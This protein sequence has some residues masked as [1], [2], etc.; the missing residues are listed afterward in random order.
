MG[1]NTKE[2]TNMPNQKDQIAKRRT[3]GKNVGDI[4]LV[5][6][7]QS[8]EE[9]E[10]MINEFIEACL[11]ESTSTVVDYDSMVSKG[12]VTVGE[13]TMLT[14]TNCG[15]NTTR[16]DHM[17]QHL[18]LHNKDFCYHCKFC[19]TTCTTQSHYKVHLRKHTGVPTHHCTDC[20]F[21]TFTST[22]LQSHINQVH[23]NDIR[24][25][26]PACKQLF[27]S[28]KEMIE[29]TKLC[30]SVLGGQTLGHIGCR[31]S[32]QCKFECQ[33]QEEMLSHVKAKHSCDGICCPFCPVVVKNN[34]EMA[35]HR[36]VHRSY[37]CTKCDFTTEFK[38][39]YIKH[40]LQKHGKS[41]DFNCYFCGVESFSKSELD[42]H[43]SEHLHVSPDF[44]EKI[45]YK[46]LKCNYSTLKSKI[47][48]KK[49]CRRLHS[50]LGK[51]SCSE[52]SYKC[53]EVA[54][55]TLHMRKH[56]DSQHFLCQHCGFTCKWP[57]QMRLHKIKHEGKK[58][59]KCS[60]CSYEAYRSDSITVHKMHKH[61]QP[62]STMCEK[63]GGS[64]ST[65]A[66]FKKHMAMHADQEK[67]ANKKSTEINNKINSEISTTILENQVASTVSPSI[68]SCDSQDS[69]L[70]P[71]SNQ[72][73][74]VELSTNLANQSTMPDSNSLNSVYEADKRQL[75][76]PSVSPKQ[77]RTLYDQKK[78]PLKTAKNKK[79]QKYVSCFICQH[80]VKSNSALYQH[81]CKQHKQQEYTCEECS[82][83]T[84]TVSKFIVHKLD[85]EK[86]TAIKCPNKNCD[87]K[88]CTRHH[89]LLH[90]RKHQQKK[91]FACRSCLYTTKWPNQLK[92]HHQQKHAG[93]RNHKCPLCDYACY[94][95]DVLKSHI[96]YRHTNAR[97]HKCPTCSY[98]AKQKRSL[99]KHM[100][101]HKN[102]RPHT[103]ATCGKSFK[104]RQVLKH[105]ERG[106][107]RAFENHCSFCK[108]RCND[109]ALF[110]DHV[111][112]HVREYESMPYRCLQCPYGAR[113]Q[114]TLAAHKRRRHSGQYQNQENSSLPNQIPSDEILLQ[115][116]YFPNVS[117]TPTTT[118]SN[119]HSNYVQP[120]TNATD[121][122]TQQIN[123]PIT[124][125]NNQPLY[126]HSNQP[127]FTTMLLSDDL[128]FQPLPSSALLLPD[129]ARMFLSKAESSN[130]NFSNVLFTDT[131][132]EDQNIFK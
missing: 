93:H 51:L 122:I 83:S 127:H 106:H 4:G 40:F 70:S 109:L 98:S 94:R 113:K 47:L 110:R 35:K 55:L 87:Y 102:E 104:S 53:S 128:D 31:M 11:R 49:H 74:D 125:P 90:V 67:E 57:S 116:C 44:P 32:K 13:D 14:C 96:L 118:L 12:L 75:V 91:K 19:K 72:L 61:R 84:S 30:Q 120:Q 112:R 66:A 69:M 119:E 42:K 63:C 80:K 115:S 9:I 101:S 16:K 58:P 50:L 130:T 7:G 38:N 46:C 77:H 3:Y 105:H 28:C 27:D 117:K 65:P 123:P 22:S 37:Y 68:I 82:F 132:N 88:A 114:K 15:H 39:Q 89:L 76:S 20:T 81:I 107:A 64:Y 59:Y 126:G 8:Q 6:D 95:A 26:C 108:F 36:K 111:Q 73:E 62:T 24:V 121:V 41:K 56:N 99:K 18:A 60:E 34:T 1:R 10:N 29:H 54:Q 86:A 52:C 97:P 71:I 23:N 129:N 17:K 48:L 45:E 103:C 124:F 21:A 92:L 131:T 100:L 79:Q 2:C 25:L 5:F 78:N 33:T 43:E 85:H